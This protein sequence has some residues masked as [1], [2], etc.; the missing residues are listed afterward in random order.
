MEDINKHIDDQLAKDLKALEALESSQESNE[1][2]KPID[3]YQAQKNVSD[4]LSVRPRAYGAPAQ[5][6]IIVKRMVD[7]FR[8]TDY[9]VNRNQYNH[10]RDAEASQEAES[11]RQSYMT[12]EFLPLVES[13]VENYGVDAIV[14]SP[15]ALA[16]L[17]DVAIT[18]NGQGDGFTK[19]YLQK[20][21]EG[22]I[23][24]ASQSDVRVQFDLAR[25]R[26]MADKGNVRGGV[27]LARQIKQQV[28]EGRLSASSDDYK[29]LSEASAWGN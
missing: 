29:A 15:T 4:A 1:T 24:E 19:A 28:D 2:Q 17:D 8:Q 23:G 22:Q 12:T 6:G 21:H 13:L 5:L 20:M 18:P 9:N 26:D 14:N 16:A 7:D 3:F 27:Q 11:L 10:L 25:A